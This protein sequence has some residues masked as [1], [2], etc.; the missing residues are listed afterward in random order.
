LSSSPVGGGGGGCLPDRRL[1]L[2]MTRAVSSTSVM[3]VRKD[4]GMTTKIKSI[5]ARQIINIRGHPTVEV[6]VVTDRCF[7]S[8]VPSG[9]SSGI[10]EAPELRDGGEVSLWKQ[11]C[12]ESCGKYQ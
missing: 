1:K 2:V 11:R 9:V 12:G 3:M 7:R 5:R 8:A 4:A 6:G 10:Y